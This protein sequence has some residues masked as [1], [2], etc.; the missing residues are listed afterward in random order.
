MK[1]KNVNKELHFYI[2]YVLDKNR[3]F[4]QNV[5]NVGAVVG[6]LLVHYRSLGMR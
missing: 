6:S 1:R 2:V 5:Q 4:G 3:K